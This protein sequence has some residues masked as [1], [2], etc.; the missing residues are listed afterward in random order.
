MEG[1]YC[2]FGRN[3]RDIYV[4]GSDA[5]GIAG[6][7]TH[8]R[9]WNYYDQPKVKHEV[10]CKKIVNIEFKIYEPVRKIMDPYKKSADPKEE[11]LQIKTCSQ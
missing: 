9:V 3:V 10:R 2:N 7:V 11:L 1:M 6:C 4:I 8:F 5:C